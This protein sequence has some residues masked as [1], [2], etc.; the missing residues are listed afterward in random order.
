[1]HPIMLNRLIV[2]GD[3]KAFKFDDFNSACAYWRIAE[4]GSSYEARKR[5][6]DYC[7]DDL[8]LSLL[9][10]KRLIDYLNFRASEKRYED[11]YE[12]AIED[13]MKILEIDPENR[14]VFYWIGYNKSLLKDYEGAII[15]YKKVL[16]LNPNDKNAKRNLNEVY[17]DM[18]K[19]R[20]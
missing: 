11:D 6:K 13:L 20:N 9:K 7:G 17:I 1:M 8:G 12:G 10:T 2:F 19:E 16:E 18:A 4:I 3:L 5:V 15:A 14:R